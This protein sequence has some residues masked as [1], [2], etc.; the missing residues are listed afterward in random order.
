MKYLYLSVFFF[1]F[2]IRANAQPAAPSPC[3][4]L[5][6]EARNKLTVVSEG[7]LNFTLGTLNSFET[8]QTYS[9]NIRLNVLSRDSKYRLY[10]AAELS[11]SG[12]PSTVIPLN[13]FQVQTA[14]VGTNPQNRIT[15][16]NVTLSGAY[17]QFAQRNNATNTAVDVFDLTV[18]LSGMNTYTQ[19]PGNYILKFHYRLCH[20]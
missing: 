7:T 3:T 18:K 4:A 6:T 2:F 19:A 11:L 20:Y 13:N 12:S 15:V 17:Q 5:G 14:L 10:V 9:N 1:G 8:E 16:S